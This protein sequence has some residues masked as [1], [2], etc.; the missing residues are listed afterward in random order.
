MIVGYS[1]GDPNYQLEG[2]PKA[3]AL[4]S[5]GQIERRGKVFGFLML[6]KS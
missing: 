3:F 6:S 5:L 1:F 2:T 4:P